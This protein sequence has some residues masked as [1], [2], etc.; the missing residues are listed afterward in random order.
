MCSFK[1]AYERIL[2]QSHDCFVGFFAFTTLPS[3]SDELP[4]TVVLGPIQ[5]GLCL[6]HVYFKSLINAC[7]VLTAMSEIE[8]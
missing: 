4:I 3:D 1:R 7:F 2:V 5:S 8:G 6:I